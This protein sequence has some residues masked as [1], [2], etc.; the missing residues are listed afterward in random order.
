M[1]RSRSS[2]NFI[3]YLLLTSKMIRSQ[4]QTL[5]NHKSLKHVSRLGCDLESSVHTVYH[6]ALASIFSLENLLQSSSR[7][8]FSYHE[9]SATPVE[10][11]NTHFGKLFMC[12]IN[13]IIIAP[14]P[15][16]LCPPPPYPPNVCAV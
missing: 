2:C 15:P 8:H 14:L 7:H 9:S 1:I 11:S 12:L 5:G 6:S 16:T 13:K 10:H 3:E 4:P